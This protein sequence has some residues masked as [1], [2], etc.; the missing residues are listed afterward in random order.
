[1]S[2]S[3]PLPR[4]DFSP[5]AEQQRQRLLHLPHEIGLDHGSPSNGCFLR[6]L[7]PGVYVFLSGE[8]PDRAAGDNFD[9]PLPVGD[10]K[11]FLL[12]YPA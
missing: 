1:M 2:R 6:D 9:F 12:S 5:S 8:G 10:I 4:V 11:T 7:L 3:L